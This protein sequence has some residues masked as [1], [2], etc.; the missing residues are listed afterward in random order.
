MRLSYVLLAAAAA[1]VLALDSTTA[2]SDAFLP[3]RRLIYPAQT[4]TPGTTAD[5]W[6]CTKSITV[7]TKKSE[8]CRTGR[9]RRRSW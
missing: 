7:K 3:S 5:S 6:G 4:K 9:R 1:L 2:T 8:V